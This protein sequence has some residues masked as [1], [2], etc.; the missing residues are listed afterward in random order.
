MR[1][2]AFWYLSAFAC[3]LNTLTGCAALA[4]KSYDYT[5]FRA[6]K[7]KSILV[8]P[9][10]ND[11]PDIRASYSFLSEVTYPLAESG[12]YVFP[13]ALVDRTF[14][15][16][17][18][19]NPPEMHQAQLSKLREIFGADAVLYIKILQ[20]GST[21]R[22]LSSTVEVKAEARLV[23][24]RSGKLLWEGSAYANDNGGGNN[25]GAHQS[26]LQQ[27]L[28]AVI[29]QVTDS[30]GDPGHDVA[31]QVS[32]QLLKAHEG[33][34]LLPGPRSPEYTKP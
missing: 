9:P 2:I 16:N 32:F 5:E 20:Y 28:G 29:K 33:T 34:G 31:R 19:N 18:L 24:A 22:L 30:V 3:V 17:G 12:Y 6:S 25:G 1:K 26:A 21:F 13:V 4:P 14:H 27:L 11:S 15:E 7:P 23:D 8:L 10:V